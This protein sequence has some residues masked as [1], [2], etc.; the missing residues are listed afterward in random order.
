MSPSP[1]EYLRHILDE[2]SYVIGQTDYVTKDRFLKDE[3]LKRAFV[4]SMEIIGEAAKNVS[5]KIKAQY[6]EVEWR[7]IYSTVIAAISIPPGID[8]ISGGRVAWKSLTL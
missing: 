5:D 1:L 4:R 8:A 2:I 3:T 7:A 6:P